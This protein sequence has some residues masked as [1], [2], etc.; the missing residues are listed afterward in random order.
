MTDYDTN[1]ES[2][3]RLNRRTALKAAGMAGA[4]LTGFTGVTAARGPGGGGPPGQSCSCDD[5]EGDF[6]AKYDYECVEEDEEVECLE[7]GFVLT[8]G[9]DVVDITITEVKDDQDDEPISIEFEADG[10]VI[11]SVCAYG[12]LD[13]DETEDEDGVTSFETNLVNPGEQQAAISNLTFCGVVEEETLPSCPFYGTTSAEPTVINAIFADVD[14]GDIVEIQVG[15][16]TNDPSSPNYPNGLAFDDANDV[17][18]YTDS[19]GVLFTLNEDGNLGEE[20]YSA[21]SPGGD[22]IA[23]AAYWDAGEEYLFIEQGG[24]ALRAA[25]LD[26][27]SVDTRV[28]VDTLPSAGI[29]LGDLAIDRD[30][31]ILYVSTTTSTDTGAS[32]FSVDLNDPDEQE[33]IVESDDT[34]T[35]AVHRQI[36]FDDEGNL[37]AH[38]AETNEW[39]VVDVN[40]GTVGAV[41]ASTQRYTDLARCGFA[42]V[43]IPEI[44]PPE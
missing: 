11:Q 35:Y 7:W 40:D 30:A 2:E 38:N 29:G 23:G 19:N 22:A 18:Y 3:Y 33:M 20:E 43:G 41:I 14:T 4:G 15:D 9:E 36:A 5:S 42:D 17:W 13:T 6:I 25:W 32:F 28:V 44:A 12:G 16:I 39:Q 8:E 34:G 21:I 26:N 1:N 24:D 27:G 10:F 37:W 31:N